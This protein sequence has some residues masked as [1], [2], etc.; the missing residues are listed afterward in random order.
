MNQS[1]KLELEGLK[2]V[3]EIISESGR[4][5]IHRLSDASLEGW[6]VTHLPRIL[7]ALTQV[8]AEFRSQ[9]Q[10]QLNALQRDGFDLGMAWVDD[11]MAFQAGDNVAAS[12]E[13]TTLPVLSKQALTIW[14]GY[15]AKLIVNITEELRKNIDT[16]LTM[17][18]TGEKSPFEIIRLLGNLPSFKAMANKQE[19]YRRIVGTPIEKAWIR[20]EYITRTEFNRIASYATKSRQDQVAEKFPEATKYWLQANKHNPRHNHTQVENETNPRKGGTPIPINDKFTLIGK[21]GVTYYV[22]SPHAPGL[23][24]GEVV[25]CGCRSV[26]VLPAFENL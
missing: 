2:R 14:Q 12:L 1:N 25:N 18:I 16:V 26:T 17:G 24:A 4:R 13:L 10:A 9:Y 23:P 22:D 19:P 15:S 20:A 3:F 11:L 7:D 5:I 21:N 8:L 6:D